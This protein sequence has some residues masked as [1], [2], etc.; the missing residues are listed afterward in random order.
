MSKRKVALVTLMVDEYE[1]AIFY[2]TKKLNFKLVEDT[3]ISKEVRT[4]IIAPVNSNGCNIILKKAIT[5]NQKKAVG[6]QCGGEILFTIFTKDFEAD[7][8]HLLRNNVPMVEPSIYGKRKRM[9][10]ED[11]YGN[12]WE[13]IENLNQAV[14]QY[15]TLMDQ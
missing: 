10:F 6:N 5:E 1:D 12:T 13:L 14:T 2:Y 4:V 15:S 9:V 8:I 3:S 11:L 7:Y